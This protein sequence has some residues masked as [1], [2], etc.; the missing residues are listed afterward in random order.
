MSDEEQVVRHI[1]LEVPKER[2]ESRR[3]STGGRGCSRVVL[4]QRPLSSGAQEARKG[5]HRRQLL[6]TGKLSG[7]PKQTKLKVPTKKEKAGDLRK[8]NV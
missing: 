2:G 4:M 6:E 3:R 8:R 5:C 7:P 1:P